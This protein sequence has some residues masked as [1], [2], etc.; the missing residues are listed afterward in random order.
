MKLKRSPKPT[1]WLTPEEADEEVRRLRKPQRHLWRLAGAVLVVA[2]VVVV[3]L[4]WQGRTTPKLDDREAAYATTWVRAHFLTPRVC[5]RGPNVRTPT[6][7]A[8]RR[9]L[10]TS[11]A[12]LALPL[13]PTNCSRDWLK[14]T[15]GAPDEGVNLEGNNLVCA[16]YSLDG[17]SQLS[18]QQLWVIVGGG[19]D[20][21]FISDD[22]L[23]GSGHW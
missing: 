16:G 11:G 7:C 12:R 19:S 15:I 17:P 22:G 2:G 1:R 14:V 10:K 23:S 8:V 3:P 21:P 5:P 9:S 4:T 6:W 18:A 20:P 13:T